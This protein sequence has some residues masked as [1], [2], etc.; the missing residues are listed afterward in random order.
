MAPSFGPSS[1]RAATPNM[2][3]VPSCM[4]VG[5]HGGIPG[6]EGVR[7]VSMYRTTFQAAAAGSMKLQVHGR[8]VLAACWR[9]R[10]RRWWW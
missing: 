1:A 6:Y 4:D 3:A 8:R 9:R 5:P 10:R 7:G 2:T